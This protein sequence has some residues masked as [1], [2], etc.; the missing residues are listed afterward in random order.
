MQAPVLPGA[1]GD[2]AKLCLSC[3]S[4]VAAPSIHPRLQLGRGHISSE[5]GRVPTGGLFWNV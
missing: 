5:K 4:G 3:L 2:F 1:P